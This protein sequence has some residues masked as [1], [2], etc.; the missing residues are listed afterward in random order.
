MRRMG[1]IANVL[2]M[3]PGMGQIKDQLA[4]RPNPSSVLWCLETSNAVW[5]IEPN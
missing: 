5:W 4:E 3:M 1:P 2:A